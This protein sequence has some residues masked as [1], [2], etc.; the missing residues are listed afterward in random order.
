MWEGGDTPLS[1]RGVLP[2]MTSLKP[3]AAAAAAAADRGA[4]A[5]VD[6]FVVNGEMAYVAVT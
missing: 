2:V 4:G 1:V 6:D 3:N 5:D